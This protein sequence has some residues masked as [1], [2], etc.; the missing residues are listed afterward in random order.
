[1]IQ[2]VLQNETYLSS[3]MDRKCRPFK[4]AKDLETVELNRLVVKVSDGLT[5][6]VAAAVVVVVSET[7]ILAML[8]AVA[9]AE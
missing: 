4:L 6:A 5:T 8:E 7:V 1:M 9:V 2:I 3:S